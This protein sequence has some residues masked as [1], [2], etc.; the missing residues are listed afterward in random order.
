MNRCFMLHPTSPSNLIRVRRWAALG[1]TLSA[2]VV[3]DKLA[4][5]GYGVEFQS[6]ASTHG[7]LRRVASISQVADGGNAD[8]NLDNAYEKN[9]SRTRLHFSTMWMDSANSQLVRLGI[10]LGPALNCKPILR[11]HQNERLAAHAKFKEYPRPWVFVCPRSDSYAC[12]QVPDGIWNEAA[13][14]MQGT[15]FWLGRHPAPPHF[16]DLKVTH[17]DNLIIWLLAADLLVTVDTGPMHMGAALGIPILALGQSSSPELHLSDQVDFLT[18]NCQGLDCLN[19][20]KN[21]CPLPGRSTNPPCQSFDPAFIS[22]WTNAKLRQKFDDRVSAVV[23]V[24]GSEPK[25]ISRC[26]NCILPQVDE[27]I[28]TAETQ[29]KVPKGIP[30]DPK[31]RV[32]VKGWKGI[33][34]GRNANYGVRH[35][36]GKWLLL[37]ND[38]VFLQPDAVSQMMKCVRSDTGMVT[39]LLRYESGAIYPT[40]MGRSPGDADWH[41]IDNGK[42][43]TSLKEC[44]ELENC[45][46]ASTL[47]RRQAFYAASGFDESFFLYCEDNDFALKMRR[48]GW[49]IMYSPSALGVHIGHLSSQK[50]GALGSL[51]APSIKL[52]HQK[53]GSYLRHNRNRIPGDFNYAS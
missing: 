34:Y 45:C 18:I 4:G 48:E 6:H 35:A 50:I 22:A 38:D 17:V 42:S 31:I 30:N 19:C 47:V 9:G 8:I 3:A 1:D 36:T 32:V 26:L 29:D 12:R 49:K 40:A 14:T 33:G 10:N 23:P 11:V 7:L 51:C 20:Q 2:T 28:V 27:I 41:H 53:W 15:K 5:L 24:Y 13:K 39:H 46:G 52:F 43:V 21:I 25:I 37:L 16:V 44:I